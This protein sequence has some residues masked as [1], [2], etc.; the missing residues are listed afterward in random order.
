MGFLGDILK[1][2]LL[3]SSSGQHQNKTYEPPKRYTPEEYVI[4]EQEKSG[5]RWYGVP[6]SELSN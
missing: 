5:E 3:D 6:L 1:G 2:L 4:Y